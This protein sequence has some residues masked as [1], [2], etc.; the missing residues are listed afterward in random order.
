[1]PAASSGAL[2]NCALVTN[3]NRIIPGPHPNI[4][5]T[6]ILVTAILGL[7]A[8]VPVHAQPF[9]FVRQFGSMPDIWNPTAVEV[10]GQNRL[11]IADTGNSRILV[12]SQTGSCDSFGEFG[13]D[14]GQF[15]APNGVLV[16]DQDR[17]L[18]AD[19]QNHR[20]QRCST[21]GACTV[22]FGQQGSG[23][24]E[25][26]YPTDL[27]FDGQGRIVITDFSN[28]RVQICTE[29]GDCTAFGAF[30]QM[31][32]QFSGPYGVV[33][34]SEEGVIV[35][36]DSGNH[37]IQLCDPEGACTV[38]GGPGTGPGQFMSPQSLAVDH[39]DRVAIIESNGNRFQFC[40]DPDPSLCDVVGS[41][42]QGEGQFMMPRGIA[43]DRNGSLIVADSMNNR[44]QIFRNAGFNINAGLNDAWY[45]PL[46][47]G[48]GFLLVVFPELEMMFAA[49]YTFDT[50]RPGQG[51][52]AMLG[53][54]GQRWLTGIGPIA[55][56]RVDVNVELTGGGIFNQ[57]LPDGSQ[58]PGY[59]TMT[60]IF[61][62][63]YGGTVTYSFPSLGLAGT[64]PIER[65]VYD[66]V[67]LCREWDAL[68]DGEE[69]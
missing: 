29:F 46:T 61:D 25:F 17:I 30:G 11:I 19:T 34:T 51:V 22:L 52:A 8:A 54:P 64:I 9:E 21:Q 69:D 23:L 24:G 15:Y 27:A 43:F 38:Y 37:R 47:A 55:G 1:M 4:V 13:S 36:A 7:A 49:L 5:S 45:Y 42:G 50:E 59:G 2:D 39:R 20:I 10:D 35:V 60:F 44:I 31:P 12:C 28:H 18:V 57:P 68:L 33:V 63:C 66:L 65:I 40:H 14:P 58:T 67:P 3:M 6:G 16:D 41:Q 32:G 48:Q 62:G 26:N 53:D 56:N